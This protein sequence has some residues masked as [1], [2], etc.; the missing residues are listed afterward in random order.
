[1]FWSNLTHLQQDFLILWNLQKSVGDWFNWSDEQNQ[2]I[3]VVCHVVI[4]CLHNMSA[5]TQTFHIWYLGLPLRGKKSVIWTLPNLSRSTFRWVLQNTI[6][7]KWLSS[8]NTLCPAAI[9]KNKNIPIVGH[10]N[11]LDASVDFSFIPPS[12]CCFLNRSGTFCS[13][14]AS[15]QEPYYFWDSPAC[16]SPSRVSPKVPLRRMRCLQIYWSSAQKKCNWKR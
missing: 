11:N 4:L 9:H 13:A 15:A 1:M 12:R 5:D 3:F 6:E 7:G 16:S 8:V 2:I 14:V 10:E